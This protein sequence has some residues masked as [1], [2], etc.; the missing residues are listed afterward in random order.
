[1]ELFGN[2][3]KIKNSRTCRRKRIPNQEPCMKIRE[4]EPRNQCVKEI[5]TKELV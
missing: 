4:V 5:R 3:K 1:M 2:C